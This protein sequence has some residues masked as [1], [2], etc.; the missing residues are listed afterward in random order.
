M[1]SVLGLLSASGD[2][3]KNTLT[4]EPKKNIEEGDES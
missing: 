1:D 2:Y 3:I 4:G